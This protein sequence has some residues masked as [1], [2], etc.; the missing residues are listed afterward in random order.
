MQDT[1]AQKLA[2]ERIDRC[3]EVEISSNIQVDRVEPDGRIWWYSRTGGETAYRECLRDAGIEQAQHRAM[4][5]SAVAAL[6]TAGAVST[7]N[8]AAPVWKVGD[9][10]AYRQEA[11]DRAVT[12]VWSVDDIEKLDGV[13]HYVVKSG[14]RNIYLRTSD[15]A[16]TLEKV[17]GKPVN[18][19]TPAWVLFGWP[20]S[21]G[22]KWEAQYHEERIDE[23]TTEEVTRTCEAGAEET[24]T[25]PAG[26]FATLL[27][28]CKNQRNGALVYQQWYAPAVKQYV[29]E[30]WQQRNGQRVRELIA[31]RLH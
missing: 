21:P 10:W 8:V 22:K 17:S 3:K 31:Y 16:V 15:G 19:Y 24:I 6:G 11:P 29:R 27:I 7:S 25:V 18:R 12:F 26:T 20:L 5:Q 4:P 13:D 14:T 23:R 1:L 2:W 9:E 30:V 28:T